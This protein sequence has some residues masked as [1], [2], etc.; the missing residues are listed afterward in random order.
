M[1]KKNIKK[2]SGPLDIVI[3]NKLGAPRGLA[4]LEHVLQDP[5]LNLPPRVVKAL[6]L[7]LLNKNTS[8]LTSPHGLAA[9][10]HL[11]QDPN[12]N[13]PPRVVKALDLVLQNKNTSPLTLDALGIVQ[14]NAHINPTLITSPNDYKLYLA[15]NK[16]L[17]LNKIKT[18]LKLICTSADEVEKIEM[19]FHNPNDPLLGMNPNHIGRRSMLKI[20]VKNRAEFGL[21]DNMIGFLGERLVFDVKDENS[22][23]E[24]CRLFDISPV[25]VNNNV[26]NNIN[27]EKKTLLKD[28]GIDLFFHERCVSLSTENTNFNPDEEIEKIEGIEGFMRLNTTPKEYDSIDYSTRATI[29][30]LVSADDVYPNIR[31]LK[32][33]IATNL[34]KIVENIFLR[35]NF[36][37]YLISISYN[38]LGGKKKSKKSRKSKPKKSKKSKTISAKWKK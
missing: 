34:Y 28:M 15:K 2:G 35:T 26:N 30:D 12:L 37:N 8:P 36:I 38:K 27:N 23:R 24:L 11:L 22:Y 21:D 29:F 4:A 18:I 10:E 32:E 14:Q 1:S 9:L 25:P 7:V 20:R 16:D 3:K 17:I 31:N 33:K 6:D 5:N 19:I 13:L